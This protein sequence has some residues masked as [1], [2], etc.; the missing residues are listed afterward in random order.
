MQRAACGG[1]FTRESQPLMDTHLAGP[2]APSASIDA[3]R[4]PALRPTGQ[5]SAAP[6]SGCPRRLVVRGKGSAVADG[7]GTPL[8]GLRALAVPASS[9]ARTAPAC[10]EGW[11]AI[12][13]PA[14]L[15][16]ISARAG[17]ASARARSVAVIF[18]MPPIG[19]PQ[20]PISFI[21]GYTPS[22]N[23][24]RRRHDPLSII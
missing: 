19:L 3:R 12:P 20:A 22:I 11:P 4:S 7:V 21:S 5:P 9:L 23:T 18:Q 8:S 17:Q 2:T 10:T 1:I 6:P 13:P 14:F 24:R 15:H 16:K